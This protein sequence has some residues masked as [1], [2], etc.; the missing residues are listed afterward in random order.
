M[1]LKVRECFSPLLTCTSSAAITTT[2]TTSYAIAPTI[3]A[4]ASASVGSLRLELY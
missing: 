1:T 4:I 2:S 3:A